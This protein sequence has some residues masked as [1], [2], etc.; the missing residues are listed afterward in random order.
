[1]NWVDEHFIM[2]DPDSN[3]LD[4]ILEAARVAVLRHGVR[5]LVIDPWTEVIHPRQN[6]VNEHEHINMCLSHVQ[7]F[8]KKYDLAAVVVAHPTKQQSHEGGGP[9]GPYQIS[10]AAGWYNKPDRILSVYRDSKS[11]ITSPTE[12]HVMKSRNKDFGRNG[13]VTFDFDPSTERYA[14]WTNPS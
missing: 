14:E 7:S 6:G 3:M 5:I 9:I 12:V 13:F 1:M 4:D 2:V 8:A 10:G 11:E